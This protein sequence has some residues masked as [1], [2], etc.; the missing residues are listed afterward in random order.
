MMEKF[1]SCHDTFI[2][3][4]PDSR[5]NRT[6]KKKR[7]RAEKNRC[8]IRHDFLFIYKNKNKQILVTYIV[9]LNFI[10]PRK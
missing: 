6:L 3:I 10:V 1:Y 7:D 8:S 5:F 9:Y 2:L 4:G